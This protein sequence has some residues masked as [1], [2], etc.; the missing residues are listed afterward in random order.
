VHRAAR[1]D[2][3]ISHSRMGELLRLAVS[4]RQTA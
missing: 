3:G 2:H 4:A 1:V